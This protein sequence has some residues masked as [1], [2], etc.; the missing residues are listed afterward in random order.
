MSLKEKHIQL[1]ETAERLF[2]EK[3][4]EG[5]S[6]RDIADEAGVNIAMISYYFGSKEKL[7]QALF[8]KK[9]GDIEIRVVSLI[10]DDS[11]SPIQKVDMLVQEHVERVMKDKKFHRIMVCEQ[12]INK[13]PAIIHLLKDIKLKN[14]TIIGELIKDGQKK[15]A[16]KKK[17][18]V[19][20]LL[21]IMFGTVN[22]LMVNH[23]FYRSFN[24]LHELSEIDYEELLKVKAATYIKKI[25]RALLL[26]ENLPG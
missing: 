15:G 26:Q 14:A 21:S 7:M 4:F 2:A 1:L 25:F 24:K 6:V 22:Q 12:I 13:N 19:V 9:I 5:T 16:F 18:D 23:D 10:K 11:L 8:E 20:M 3:G 17:V